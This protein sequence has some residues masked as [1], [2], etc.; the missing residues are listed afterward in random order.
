MHYYSPKV[1]DGE[2]G[3]APHPPVYRINYNLTPDSRK[4]SKPPSNLNSSLHNPIRKSLEPEP[5]PSYS[6]PTSSGNSQKCVLRCLSGIKNPEVQASFEADESPLVLQELD[7][8][9]T[10]YFKKN[11]DE[12]I[13]Q[14]KDLCE[15]LILEQQIIKRKIQNQEFIINKIG[16]RGDSRKDQSINFPSIHKN[17]NYK[18]S[19]RGGRYRNSEDTI[20][21]PYPDKKDNENFA[22]KLAE[23]AILP[24]NSADRENVDYSQ[25]LFSCIK[26]SP[27]SESDQKLFSKFSRALNSRSSPAKY[28]KDQ[29]KIMR[30]QRFPKEVFTPK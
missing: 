4:N 1:P 20:N 11:N 12:N 15:K 28:Y 17:H 14:L 3:R 22:I 25:I 26:K 18:H 21:T 5:K 2:A 6:S 10:P 23:S 9:Q 8:V 27:P 24:I 19:S 13:D 29:P 30:Y 7:R 16:S